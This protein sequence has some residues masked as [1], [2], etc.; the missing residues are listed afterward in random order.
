MHS[1]IIIGGG[2]VGSAMALAL[3]QAGMAVE[4]VEAKRRSDQLSPGFDGRTSAIAA[5]SVKILESIGVWQSLK[6]TS[7]ITDIRVYEHGGRHHVHYDCAEAGGEP[8][9]YIVEN[10]LLRAA[11]FDAVDRQH[12]ITVHEPCT[13]ASYETHGGHITALLSDGCRLRAPLLLVADG[14][15]S[16]TREMAGIAPDIQQYGQTAIVAS[17]SHSEPHHG[18]AVEAFFPSGPFAIL[19]MTGQRSNIVWSEPDAMA[20]HYLSLPDEAFLQEIAKRTGDHLGRLSLTGPRYSYPLMLI[21]AEQSI[22]P[23]MALIGDA[24]HGIH[25][26]AGQ[27]VNLGYR[28][29]AVLAE[30]LVEQARL[31]LDIGDAALLSRYAE[32][33]RLDVGSMSHATD[34]LNRLFSNPNPLL[35]LVRDSGLGLVEQLPPLK[36]FFMTHAMGMGGEIPKMMRGEAL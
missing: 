11:L 6:D 25:P 19:P 21:R 18:L 14:K 10:R 29:V 26:I 36:R 35:R 28:D 4:L 27:G 7:P 23:R 1:V 5:A 33:R 20:A 16:K 8:F 15:L 32:R 13:L 2:L 3:A 34:A 24:A 12:H 30:M 17:I 9:G 31:G 22:A